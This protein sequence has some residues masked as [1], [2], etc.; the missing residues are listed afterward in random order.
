M[1]MMKGLK[2]ESKSGLS[3][4]RHVIPEVV[5]GA[6]GKRDFNASLDTRDPATALRLAGPI[7]ADWL[8]RI[9]R[10]RISAFHAKKQI[11]I[12]SEPLKRWDSRAFK[13]FAR[14][15]QTLP[16]IQSA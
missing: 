4:L 13:R 3:K 14:R 8:E 16:A 5:R 10:A 2:T 11:D 1:Q 7:K 12:S 9:Q 6:L 15:L